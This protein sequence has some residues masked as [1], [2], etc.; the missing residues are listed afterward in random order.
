VAKKGKFI[1]FEG[2]E[3]SGK[4]TQSRF[5]VADLKRKG[6]KVLYTREPGGTKIGER[7]RK[8]L[9]DPKSKGMSVECETLLYLA[10]RAQIVS[11]KILPALKRG[12]IVVCDRFHDA[13]VA[14]QG[15]GGKVSLKKLKAFRDFTTIGTTPD[16]TILLDIESKKGLGRS[17]SNDR[18]EQKALAY[19]RKVRQGYLKIAK[20]SPGRVKVIRTKHNIHQTQE[21]VRKEVYRCL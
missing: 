21:L 4:S 13:T 6:F 14:Y 11:E 9:L 19:H 1:T 17:K 8:I 3:G 20:A 16:L 7:I 18:I 2:P 10:N 15:Y 5:M 12:E